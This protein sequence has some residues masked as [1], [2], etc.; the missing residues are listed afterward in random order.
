MPQTLRLLT[1]ALTFAL[2]WAS[3]AFPGSAAALPGPAAPA[4]L[5]PA[6]PSPNNAPAPVAPDAVT[7]TAA[8]Q[9]VEIYGSIGN[10]DGDADWRPINAY[11]YLVSSVPKYQH[12]YSTIYNAYWDGRIPRLDP[13]TNKWDVY[14]PA[15]AGGPPLT[16]LF[17]PT[18][19]FRDQLNQYDN[20]ADRKRYIHTIGNRITIQDALNNNSSLATMLTKAGVLKLCTYGSGSCLSRVKEALF[21]DKFA[22]FSQAKDSTGKL[23]NNVV[24]VTSSNLNG[25]SGGNKSNI[26]FAIY[27][28]QT[29]YNNLLNNLWTPSM[30]QTVTPAFTAA[31]SGGFGSSSTDIVYYPSPRTT[32]F[33]GTLLGTQT[34]SKLGGKKSGC[35]VYVVHSL[36]SMARQK[37]ADALA[38]L[39]K[40]GCSVKVVVGPPSVQVITDTYFAMSKK[41]RK[42]ID[43]FEFANVHD[44]TAT[45]SYTLNGAKRS[46][47][48][49]GSANFNGTSLSGDELAVRFTNAAVVQAVEDRSQFVYTLAKA[50]TK[51][52]PVVSVGVSPSTAMV[53]AGSNITLKA[54]VLP[55]NASVRSVNWR[56]SDTSVAR[57]DEAGVVT[58]LK[59]GIVTIS[60]VSVS[61]SKTGTAT[62]NVTPAAAQ[63]NDF[64]GDGQ[65]DT[66]VVR[67]G[68][69]SARGSIEIRYG[70]GTTQTVRPSQHGFN[71]SSAIHYRQVV[72]ADVNTDGYADL[73]VGAPAT[74]SATSTETGRVY[75]IYGSDAGLR[76]DSIKRL[77]SPVDSAPDAS[78]ANLGGFGTSVAVASTPYPVILVGDPWAKTSTGLAGGLVHGFPVTNGSYGDPIAISQNSPGV[79]GADEAG[80][81]FGY[82]LAASGNN[83][84]V[85]IPDEAIGT[86]TKAGSVLLFRFT[87]TSFKVSGFD[88]NVAGVPD[89]VETGDRF[90]LTL[91][92]AGNNAVIGIPN[93][94]V[95]S[96]RDAGAVQPL[97]ITPTSVKWP[98]LITQDTSGV[99][100]GTEAGDLFGRSVQVA[101][102]CS[103][104]PSYLVGVPGEDLGTELD[105]G[106]TQLIPQGITSSC[107]VIEYTNGTGRLGGP[108]LAGEQVP[109]SLSVIRASATAAT[110]TLVIGGRDNLHL[111]R[112]PFTTVANRIAI[113]AGSYLVGPLG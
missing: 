45:I 87:Q 83:A 69:D 75:V 48:F 112:T 86:K 46:Y 101:R 89:S 111:V 25:A 79:P 20:D 73:V 24:W 98:A 113:S 64:D 19:A 50:G 37:V 84:L 90:G 43:N 2:V 32:D 8:G 22:L 54:G 105:R 77:D 94:A 47:A 14:D 13:V 40:D 78:G 16:A 34:N 97:T 11:A 15:D 88:Q 36:F 57:V 56:S 60:A 17:A 108:A 29:G 41:L 63:I 74:N 93:E 52:I 27:G 70:K 10:L 82:S 61:G 39:K 1:A 85:G 62:L 7:T 110:D 80:D 96:K 53:M 28:D 51:R 9:R 26:S 72:A 91:S 5:R 103:G 55:T 95:G 49:G 99:P 42:L 59:P 31:A 66:A 65:V 92:M 6:D 23:W 30:N 109:T 102:Q 21:H 71:E 67:P 33:E 100:G 106:V 76:T 58:T 68:S 18:A 35:K 81:A 12:I 107:K 38:A 3:T 4:I 44:K 104:K